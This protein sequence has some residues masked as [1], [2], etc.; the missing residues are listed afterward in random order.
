MFPSGL[1]MLFKSLGFDPADFAAKIEAAQKA[2]VAT[3]QHFDA[4]LQAI[5]SRLAN[6]ERLLI[7]AQAVGSIGPTNATVDNPDTG[8]P[9]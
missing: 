5:D 8:K 2:A 3:V 9:Q 6:L 7:E 1:Q 4:R